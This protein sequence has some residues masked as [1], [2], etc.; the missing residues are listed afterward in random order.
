MIRV[1]APVVLALLLFA[2]S[3]EDSP[4]VSSEP[5]D[6]GDGGAA[7]AGCADVLAATIERTGD[8]FTVSAT[9]RS[10]DTGWEKYADAFEVRAPDGT[11]LGTRIL[12]HPHVE[13]Q[14]FTRSLSGL[15]IPAGV[16][17]ITVAARDLVVGFCGDVVTVEVP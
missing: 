7:E 17:E 16:A 1:A 11:V 4:Q 9:V 15:E 8:T 14:P 5:G 10:A 2:C 6:A 13:E 12:T 3:A